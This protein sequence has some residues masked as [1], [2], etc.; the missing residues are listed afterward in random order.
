MNNYKRW[1]KLAGL[2]QYEQADLLDLDY[3]AVSK[4]ERG[5]SHPSVEHYQKLAD[6]WGVSIDE[7]LDEAD[8]PAGVEGEKYWLSE[9]EAVLITML[10]E[11][12]GSATLERMIEQMK[13]IQVLTEKLIDPP[14]NPPKRRIYLSS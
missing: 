14:Q 1:R 3:Q 11:H 2:K 13:K 12:G 8:R 10:R 7:I 9:R 4:W 6:I 5:L